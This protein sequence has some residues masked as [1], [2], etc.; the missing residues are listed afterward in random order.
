MAS[1]TTQNRFR[2]VGSIVLSI[3]A[4][5]CASMYLIRH[6]PTREPS[7]VSSG[8]VVVD[9]PS[10]T[11]PAPSSHEGAASR[12]NEHIRKPVVTPGGTDDEPVPLEED[13]PPN[14]RLLAALREAERSPVA[15][16]IRD[17]LDSIPSTNGR[18][19]KFNAWML[20]WSLAKDAAGLAE[21]ERTITVLIDQPQSVK[22]LLL[23]VGGVETVEA[24]SWL[25]RMLDNSALS[26]CEEDVLEALHQAPVTDMDVL[27]D[28]FEQYQHGEGTPWPPGYSGS[29]WPSTDSMVVKATLQRIGEPRSSVAYKAATLLEGLSYPPHRA[30]KIDEQTRLMLDEAFL[31][32][33]R[34]SVEKKWWEV[35]IQY[36]AAV[37]RPEVA[38]ALWEKFSQQDPHS[39]ER[40]IFAG[41]VAMQAQSASDVFRV[42][43]VARGEPAVE[44]R[45][46][47][48]RGLSNYLKGSEAER[49]TLAETISR[50]VAYDS[51]VR[52]RLAAVEVLGRMLPESERYLEWAKKDSSPAVREK[53]EQVLDRASLRSFGRPR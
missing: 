36:L 31:R 30:A 48:L 49:P 43:Q 12:W 41:P 44:V 26:T 39:I 42:V 37:K 19:L 25:L 29:I 11:D 38:S 53:L 10:S 4:C 22:T 46:S 7:D 13:L 5:L 21:V 51:E 34:E 2:S 14:Q 1:R 23:I 27:S 50:W 15:V 40:G 47:M 33:L 45:E 6:L 28:L 8:V 20:A 52:V 18:E 16:L 35:A 32:L 17:V 24:R 3:V 9:A